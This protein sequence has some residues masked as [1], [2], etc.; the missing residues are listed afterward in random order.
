MAKSNK[1][2]IYVNAPS[3]AIDPSLEKGTFGLKVAPVPDQVPADKVL[4]RVHYLSLDPA[5]RQM[6]TAKRSYIAPV[7]RGSVMRGQSIAQVIAVGSSLKNQYK[8]GEWVTAMSGWQEYALLGVKEARKVTI[9]KGGRVTDVLSVLGL[10]GL[11]AYFGLL[12]VAGVKPGDTVVVSGAAGA[13][14]SVAGQIAKIK[15]AKRV[16]GLAGSKDKCDH[17]KNELGFDFAINYRDADW[18][19]QL[20]DATPEY[21]DVFF[22][23]VGGEILDACL[24][25][26]AQNARFAIC[27]AISQYNVA[28]PQG[29]SSYMNIISMRITMKGFITFDFIKQ[30]PTA[31]KD[32]ATWLSEGKIKRKEHIVKGGVEAAPQALVDLFAGR[33][34]GKMMVEVTPMSESITETPR[35][36]L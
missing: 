19:R 5:M 12:E 20:K 27:G 31:L 10:T 15:G 32:L 36:N 11:T 13:T 9:P 34:T 4:V 7:E 30:Y 24:A 28:K 17:L 18:R 26:A 6:L 14:G 21:I 29:P 1:Q 8:A 35:A 22:D 23:N 16:I 3:P 2:L 25:R 33:N